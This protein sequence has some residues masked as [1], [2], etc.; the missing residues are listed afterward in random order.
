MRDKRS[1]AAS[2]KV[3][4]VLITGLVND[5]VKQKI[6]QEA[7]RKRKALKRKSQKQQ[8]LAE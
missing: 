3:V 4:S 1:K 5:I 7:N 8:K 6:R 2:E